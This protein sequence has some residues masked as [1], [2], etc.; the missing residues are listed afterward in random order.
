MSRVQLALNV[1]DLEA[2][3]DF[4]TKLFKTPPAKIRENYANFAIAEPPLKLVLIAGHGQPGSLNHVGVEVESTDEVAAEA[5]RMEA[6]G[7]ECNVREATSC[8]YAVQDKVWVT[9]PEI[10]W[11]IYTVLSDAEVLHGDGGMPDMSGDAVAVSSG[12]SCC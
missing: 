7:A 1:G 11:E 4:Y 8:C 2:S 3:I 10:P 6:E 9:G 12:T 5:A